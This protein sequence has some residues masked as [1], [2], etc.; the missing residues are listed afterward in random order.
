M[1]AGI[2]PRRQPIPVLPAAHYHMGGVGADASGATSLPGLFAAGEC[3]ATGVHGANRLASNS[4]LE[5]A[6]FGHRAGEAAREAAD[7]GTRPLPARQP[8]D[9]SSADLGELRRRMARDAG[10]VRDAAG[11][12]GLIGW[13]DDLDAAPGAPLPLVA[14]RLVARA[15]LDRRESRGAHFRAD[16]PATSA[17]AVHTVTVLAGAPDH[18]QAA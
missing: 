2:D 7:P 12:E 6:V 17:S 15:A 4:L 16:H 11:L 18:R 10:V 8:R 3:A 1:A 5:A 14:A 9:L 13:L